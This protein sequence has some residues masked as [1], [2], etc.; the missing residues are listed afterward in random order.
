MILPRHR[1]LMLEGEVQVLTEVNGYLRAEKEQLRA[2]ASQFRRPQ[3]GTMT[4][5]Q[6]I[7]WLGID[8]A[9]KTGNPFWLGIASGGVMLEAW[10]WCSERN[11]FAG[12]MSGQTLAE[13]RAQAPTEKIMYAEMVAPKRRN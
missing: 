13:L 2:L 11:D 12:V 8:A 3:D 4:M 1:I 9:P 6:R 5:T 7:E 10:H